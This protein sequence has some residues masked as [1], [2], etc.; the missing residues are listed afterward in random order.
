[1][2]IHTSV[3]CNPRPLTC[4]GDPRF[5]QTAYSEGPRRSTLRHVVLQFMQM[6]LGS[7]FLWSF[8]GPLLARTWLVLWT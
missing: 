7:V 8:R 3:S 4:D 2:C 6:G 5:R 1:M